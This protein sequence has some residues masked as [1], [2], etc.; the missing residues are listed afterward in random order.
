MFELMRSLMVCTAGGIL[1]AV[2]FLTPSGAAVGAVNGFLVGI[3][4][5]MGEWRAKRAEG[6]LMRQ[7]I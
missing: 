2:V 4:V 3:F 1:L 7:L 6:S 5:C